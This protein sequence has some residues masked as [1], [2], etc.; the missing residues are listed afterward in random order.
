MYS[1]YDDVLSRWLEISTSYANTIVAIVVIV[2]ERT[3]QPTDLMNFSLFYRLTKTRS[4]LSSNDVV[5]SCG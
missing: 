2:T 1:L 5:L 4:S 3:N